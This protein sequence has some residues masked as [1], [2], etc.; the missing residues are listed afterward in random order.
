MDIIK[1]DHA[2]A[3]SDACSL[4]HV[5]SAEAIESMQRFL[6]NCKDKD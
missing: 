6:Q 4:E 1:I 5:I 2:A 3:D